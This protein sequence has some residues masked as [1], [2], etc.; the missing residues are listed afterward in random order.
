MGL[1]ECD[2]QRVRGVCVGP[3]AREHAEQRVA[4]VG[5]RENHVRL[6]HLGGGKVGAPHLGSQLRRAL[7]PPQARTLL[8]RRSGVAGSD[9][10]PCSCQAGA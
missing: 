9:M 5:A 4:L 3:V 8:R 10:G 7:M 2:G 1:R 6:A